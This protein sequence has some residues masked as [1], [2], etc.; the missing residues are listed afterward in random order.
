MQALQEVLASGVDSLFAQQMLN[1]SVTAVAS[2][3]SI[4]LF[5]GDSFSEQVA[6]YTGKL[7][8]QDKVPVG[9]SVGLSVA[10][11]AILAV[12][13]TLAVYIMRHRRQNRQQ[14]VNPFSH[15]NPLQ[16][17]LALLSNSTTVCDK[18]SCPQVAISR[19]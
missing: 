15:C 11:A 18:M 2:A 8:D 6:D 12:T 16:N 19:V 17:V 10:G 9:L 5:P 3:S 1:Y 13:A 7:S 4:E 14:K